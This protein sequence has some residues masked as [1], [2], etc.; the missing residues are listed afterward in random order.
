MIRAESLVNASTEHAFFTRRGG[1]SSGIYATLNC[2][3]GSGDDPDDINENRSLAADQLGIPEPLLCTMYQVHG[4]D[5]VFVTKPWAPDQRPRADAMVTQTP[6]LALGI[7]T[8]DCVP[9]LFFDPITKTIGAAHAGWQGALKGIVGATVR[10]MTELGSQPAAIK[11]AIG[12]AIQQLSYEV[13]PDLHTRFLTRD[14]SHERF[15]IPSRKAGH[16]MLDLPGFVEAELEKAGLLEIENLNRD[17]Y[18]EHEFFF[19]YRRA[20]HRGETDYGRQLS[21]IALVGSWPT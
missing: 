10:A 11:A 20:T 1:V 16:F 9:V 13:G 18:D 8:A 4:N 12:P 21:A 19:S 5:V 15:F 3:P 14:D 6:G 2:G 17:T 7:L